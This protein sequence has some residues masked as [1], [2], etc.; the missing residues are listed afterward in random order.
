[1]C[2]TSVTSTQTKPIRDNPTSQWERSIV[3]LEET[4][5][6]TEFRH[7]L[8]FIPVS[9]IAAQYYCELKVDH[10]YTHGEVP[11]EAKQEGSTLHDQ[12]LEM[13]STTRENLI[14]Q[15]KERPICIASFLIGAKING[16]TIAGIPDAIVFVKGKPTILLELKTTKR[17]LRLWKDQEVQAKTYALLLERMGFDCSSLQIVVAKIKRSK[18]LQPET[19]VEFLRKL[20]KSLLDRDHTRHKIEGLLSD[21]SQLFTLTYNHEEI[22]KELEWAKQYWLEKREPIPTNQA[23]KCRAC[24]FK[25]ICP[26]SLA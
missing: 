1:M 4:L 5:Q 12:L 18:E 6:G 9:S 21:K 16:L 22:L 3:D 13:E 7:N 8:P 23:G 17:E 19:K 24:E 10:E 11:S 14:Q 20:I 26:A 15:V 25:T 2:K